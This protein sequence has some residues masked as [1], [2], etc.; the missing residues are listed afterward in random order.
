MASSPACKL[1]LS[2]VLSF[3]ISGPELNL[4]Y[5]HINYFSPH[6]ISVADISISY[7]EPSKTDAP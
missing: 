3:I 5:W 2:G 7:P 1:E 4:L 6:R